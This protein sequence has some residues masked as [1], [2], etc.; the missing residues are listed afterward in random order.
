[1]AKELLISDIVPKELTEVFEKVKTNLEIIK[2][3]SEETNELLKSVGAT[4]IAFQA[5]LKKIDKDKCLHMWNSMFSN[6][7]I[8]RC[9]KCGYVPVQ[10]C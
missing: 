10:P 3:L 1:M 6:G 9:V 7:N 4:E 2:Q 8:V 5:D